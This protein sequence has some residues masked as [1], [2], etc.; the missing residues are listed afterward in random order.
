MRDLW[1]M[2]EQSRKLDESYADRDKHQRLCGNCERWYSK[3]FIHRC[4]PD[5][6]DIDELRNLIL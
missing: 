3:Y 6:K 5:E 1:D 4:E 2:E